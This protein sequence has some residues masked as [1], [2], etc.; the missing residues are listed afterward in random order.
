MV[1][2]S[3]PDRATRRWVVVVAVACAA[4]LAVA[5]GVY[6]WT[7]GGSAPKHPVAAPPAP[8]SSA[9]TSSAPQATSPP[10]RPPPKKPVRHDRVAPA[11]PTAFTLT[12]RKFTIKAEVCSMAPVFPLD[13]PGDQHHTVCWVDG[14]FGVAPSS[15]AATSYVLGHAWAPDSKEVLNKLSAPATRQVLKA[16][17]H[18]VDGVNVYPVHV[19]DG[20]K[21]I[22][23]TPTGRLTYRVSKAYGVRKLDLGHVKSAM[24]Q[25]ARNRVVLITCAERKGVD[26]DYNIVLYARLHS[27]VRAAASRA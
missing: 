7:R 23:R 22:L 12:G 1:T 10:V 13:P 21:L 8:S 19:L 4:L 6:L 9:A 24:N 16:E 5:F 26:Y 25:H 27:S 14:G 20:Y 15:H 2:Y 17:P 18:L 11:A 3:Q